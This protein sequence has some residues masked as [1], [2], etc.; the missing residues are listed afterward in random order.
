[1]RR[2]RKD[3]IETRWTNRGYG[4]AVPCVNVK[5][6]YWNHTSAVEDRF[7]CSQAVAEQ[8]LTYAWESAAE[9]FWE[10]W[11]DKEELDFYFPGYGARVWQDG[12][13]G[14]WLIVEGLPDVE[15][16]DAIMVGRWAKFARAVR[17]DVDY[18]TG[19]ESMLET[20]E[21]NRWAEPESE[22]Y[23]FYQT[24]DGSSVCLVDVNRATEKFRREFIEKHAPRV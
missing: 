10:Y 23:N 2:F 12:R 20:I 24:K 19:K 5:A 18:R 1:M 15:T 13:S 22:R 17:E 9:G 3:D 8:A 21:V 14:G 11:Q 4:P 7:S 6:H 16:W